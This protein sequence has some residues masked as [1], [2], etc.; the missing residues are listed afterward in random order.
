MGPEF[1]AGPDNFRA[2]VAL[3]KNGA[4]KQRN[5]IIIS[6]KSLSLLTTIRDLAD[7]PL[8]ITH[9]EFSARVPGPSS[10]YLVG[11]KLNY[12]II[13]MASADVL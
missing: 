6:T 9:I 8:K 10:K 1:A 2:R 11:E 4:S 3:I 5:P 7:G 12:H 13:L